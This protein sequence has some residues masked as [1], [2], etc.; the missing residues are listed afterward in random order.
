MVTWEN[1]ARADCAKFSSVTTNIT[2]DT[3]QLYCSE[4]HCFPVAW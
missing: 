2:Y 4:S 3:L 1:G